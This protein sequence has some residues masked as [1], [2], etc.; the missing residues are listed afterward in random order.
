MRLGNL[1][2][3]RG[4]ALPEGKRYWKLA[5]GR[6]AFPQRYFEN[7]WYAF[8]FVIFKRYKQLDKEGWEAMCGSTLQYAFRIAFAY[9][10]P[11]YPL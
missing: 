4:A 8:E 2:K 11:F 1:P 9:W 5:I 3:D 7:G 6:N 10:L